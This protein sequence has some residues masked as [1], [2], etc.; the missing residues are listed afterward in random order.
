MCISEHIKPWPTTQVLTKPK[1][2][3]I[4]IAWLRVEERRNATKR[5]VLSAATYQRLT[6]AVKI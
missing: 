2:I 5:Y 4:P 3:C 1:I 6:D